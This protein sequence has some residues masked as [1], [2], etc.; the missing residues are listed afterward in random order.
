M[1]LVGAV[2]LS[3]AFGWAGTRMVAVLQSL[4]PYAIVV[5]GAIA[6]AALYRG[7][8]RLAFTSG[9]VGIGGLWLAVPLVFSPGQPSPADGATGLRVAT[10][11]LLFSND[12]ID[13]AADALVVQSPDV[14]V[15]SEFTAEHRA[16]LGDHPFA[17]GYGHR[18]ERE[19]FGAG[20]I[21]IWSRF[22]LSEGDRL[23]TRNYSLDVSVA[24]P[25]GP[26][27]LLG[28]HAPTPI[29]NFS[30]W[31]ADLGIVDDHIGAADG[32]TLVIGDFNASYWHPGFRDLLDDGFVDAHMAHGRGFSTSWPTDR[33]FPP[34]VRLDHALTGN[35]LVSTA[36]SDF[37]VPGSDHRGF[38]VTVAPTKRKP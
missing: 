13:E 37:D 38:V 10:V 33:W 25:D 36:V 19:G 6:V 7:E 22:P 18:V 34:F 3:Q 4:T 12:V 15:F 8:H 27:D 31:R 28:V 35:G 20:G 14:V 16:M 24:G 9:L 21:A 17:E 5:L 29:A 32:P 1:A 2:M 26:V 23:A 30:G 11:N